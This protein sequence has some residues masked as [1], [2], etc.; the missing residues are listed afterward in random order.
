MCSVAEIN[1]KMN[2]VLCSVQQAEVCAGILSDVIRC[3]LSGS[4][5][6]LLGL[7][8]ADVGESS[9]TARGHGFKSQ[10]DSTPPPSPL[11]HS[12]Y[13]SL[14]L[15][16]LNSMSPFSLSGSLD[17]FGVLHIFPFSKSIF[18]SSLLFKD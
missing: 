13:H 12:C 16:H 11:S 6:C 8:Y 17:Q 14:F 2:A 10:D 1:Q 4:D 7:G 5:G 3:V 18:V 9:V 15:Y